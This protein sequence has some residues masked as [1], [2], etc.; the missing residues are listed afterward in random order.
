MSSV[1]YLVALTV[2][3]VILLDELDRLFSM[4]IPMPIDVQEM[5]FSNLRANNWVEYFWMFTGAVIAAPVIEESLYRGML[6]NS[7]ESHKS[8]PSAILITSVVFAF[9]HLQPWW[10]IQL[11]I[12]SIF[13]G[14]IA[15]TFDSSVPCIIIHAGN[16]LRMFI[17]INNKSYNGKTLPLNDHIN[18]FW[19]VLAIILVVFSIM[20]LK[21][22]QA[23]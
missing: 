17:A 2:G 6:Q 20:K 7:I 1:V 18:L 10:I 15:W 23:K 13:M 12:F 14:Y 4:V 21:R 16:N 5:I 22:Y 19:I 11:F 8:A 3:S 9:M